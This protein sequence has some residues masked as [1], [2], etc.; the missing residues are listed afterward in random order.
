MFP[1]HQRSSCRRSCGAHNLWEEFWRTATLLRRKWI[2]AVGKRCD[3]QSRCQGRSG[4]W[5]KWGRSASAACNVCQGMRHDAQDGEVFSWS[6]QHLSWG[7]RVAWDECDFAKGASCA[8]TVRVSNVTC[9]RCICLHLPSIA[10]ELKFPASENDHQNKKNYKEL[11]FNPGLEIAKNTCLQ[12]LHRL[13]QK[14]VWESEIWCRRLLLL[15]FGK[16]MRLVQLIL[17]GGNQR[18]LWRSLRE[19]RLDVFAFLRMFCQL[20]M[21]QV[22]KF[23]HSCEV[24]WRQFSFQLRE[25]HLPY[26]S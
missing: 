5:G 19:A 26:A 16:L 20:R 22:A 11:L 4:R 12:K 14:Q 3:R 24:I 13:L 7:T 23:H 9:D 2:F 15:S 6:T 25:L 10:R 21:F 8:M 17:V 1:G 18:R